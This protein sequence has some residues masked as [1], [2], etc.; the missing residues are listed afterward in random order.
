MNT[1]II[2]QILAI[3]ASGAVNMFDSYT[4]QYLA[5]EHG[6]YELVIFIEDNRRM[7]SNFILTGEFC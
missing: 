7:Y 6:F 5:N 4:V 2:N 3:R 1:I